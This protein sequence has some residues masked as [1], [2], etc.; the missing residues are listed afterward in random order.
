[1]APSEDFKDCI[2]IFQLVHLSVTFLLWGRRKR[3]RKR[4]ERE[5]GREKE[6]EKEREK[7][8]KERERERK[9]ERERGNQ[10]KIPSHNK[11]DLSLPLTPYCIELAVTKI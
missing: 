7:G 1:M 8:E 5:K 3:E 6:R 9:K 10:G 2:K 4:G 11:D